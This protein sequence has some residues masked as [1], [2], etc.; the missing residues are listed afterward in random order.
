MADERQALLIHLDADLKRRLRAAAGQHDR[1]MSA[2][3]RA[4]IDEH[5]PPTEDEP[6][7]VTA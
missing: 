1:S 3:V 2:H 7:A 5:T 4:L 6:A